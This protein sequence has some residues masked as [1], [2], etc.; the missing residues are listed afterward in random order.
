MTSTEEL[1]EGACIN[2]EHCE[3]IAPGA[4]VSD[5]QMC[6]D[7]LDAVRDFGNGLP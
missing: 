1:P 6:D 7:C 3:N 5:N 4:P 2:Y